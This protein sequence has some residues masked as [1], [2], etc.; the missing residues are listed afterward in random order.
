MQPSSMTS[1]PCCSECGI[2]P[3]KTLPWFPVV[4]RIKCTPIPCSFMDLLPKS[5]PPQGLSLTVPSAWMLFA[6]LT[7][8]LCLSILSSPVRPR[9]SFLT[10][11]PV[12]TACPCP[13][14]LCSIFLYVTLLLQ[15]I[16]SNLLI[17][18]AMCSGSALTLP[19]WSF[20]NSGP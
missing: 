9:R 1:S 19:A 8:S 4:L 13:L 15:D 18:A 11:S 3:C 12:Y 16:F 2:L 17:C 20:T 5:L 10:P 6:S 7:H 14:S